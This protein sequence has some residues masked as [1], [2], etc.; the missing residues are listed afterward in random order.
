[1]REANGG[2]QLAIRLTPADTHLLHAGICNAVP[3]DV[4]LPNAACLAITCLLQGLDD[5]IDKSEVISQLV[6]DGQENLCQQWV[7]SLGKDYQVRHHMA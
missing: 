5:A 6:G 3:A 4:L 7:T 2:G 1:M